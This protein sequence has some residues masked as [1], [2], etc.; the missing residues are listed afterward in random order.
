MTINRDDLKKLTESDVVELLEELDKFKLENKQQAEFLAAMSH[1]LRTPLNSVIGFTDLLLKSD[2]YQLTD[3]TK[4][5]LTIIN[6]SGKHLLSLIKDITVISKLKLGKM[7]FNEEHVDIQQLLREAERELG[8]QLK[9][10]K[11]RLVSI[12]NTETDKLI[13]IGDS[14]RIKQVLINLLTNAIKHNSVGGEISTELGR[15]SQGDVLVSISD[16]GP[17]FDESALSQIFEPF[18]KLNSTSHPDEGLGLGLTISKFIIES[19]KGQIGVE[20]KLSQGSRFW[21]SLPASEVEP[22]SVKDVNAFSELNLIN[23]DNVRDQKATK[24]ILYVED[25]RTSLVLV[26]EFLTHYPN[27]EFIAATSGEEGL[28]LAQLIDPDLI[29]MDIDLPLLD[30]H[31]ITR[32]LKKS[33]RLNS[34]PIVGLSSHIHEEHIDTA[35]SNGMSDYLIKPLDLHELNSILMKYDLI[36]S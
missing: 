2:K 17:G 26:K 1:E 35:L 22:K 16:T 18:S 28:R 20:S 25:D 14:T 12:A 8:T 24:R 13:A 10:A 15:S 27:I 19:M 11:I 33:K 5:Y 23:Q 36:S 34:V 3:K 7:E 30:G 29:L 21:F 31:Q 6:S 32:E 4:D 9:E